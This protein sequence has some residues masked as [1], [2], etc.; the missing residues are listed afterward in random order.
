MDTLIEEK[1]ESVQIV[2]Q[3][4]KSA[5]LLRRNKKIMLLLDNC[6]EEI[7]G[8]LL[9]NP[10]ITVF[11]KPAIQHRNIGFFS[12]VSIGYY[13]SNQLMPSQPLGQCLTGL[14]AAVNMIVK[15]DFNGIL[16]NE[17]TNGIDYIGQHSDDEKDLANVGVVA[18]SYGQE[19]L[20]RI[21]NKKTDLKVKDIILPHG[22]LYHMAGDFQKEFKHGI[23]KQ[24]KIK[25]TRI[26]FT[27]RRHT[28]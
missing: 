12:D 8:K 16:V 28:K 13:Y 2:I 9:K 27:F 26:S 18:I 7:Q 15:G 19:R 1:E 4:K 22:S 5:L 6:V 25:G 3:T 10:P 17:Y 11:G 20:L 21:T 23:P 24:A 14:L